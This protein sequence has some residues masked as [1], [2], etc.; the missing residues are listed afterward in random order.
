VGDG[1]DSG[2]RGIDPKVRDRVLEQI[3]VVTDALDA[4]TANP[5][6]DVLDELSEAT[7]KLMRALGRVL[8]EVERQRGTPPH[9]Q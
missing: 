3:P 5:T 1:N 8:L 6:A 9:K 2:R 7:D 4:A